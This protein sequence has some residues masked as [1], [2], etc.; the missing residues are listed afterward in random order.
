MRHRFIRTI[1]DQHSRAWAGFT[2]VELLVY[3]GIVSLTLLAIGA[4]TS[5]TFTA[6]LRSRAQRAVSDNANFLLA[7]LQQLSASAASLAVVDPASVELTRP[8]GG[9]VRLTLT[10]EGRLTVRVG[11]GAAEPVTDL[12]VA[13]TGTFTDRSSAG[14]SRNLGVHLEIT[15]RGAEVSDAVAQLTLDTAFELGAE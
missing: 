11:A 6:G 2:L 14:R 13:V 4:M 8:D 5:D 10:P 15:S 7:R 3:V 12:T 1:A 9:V